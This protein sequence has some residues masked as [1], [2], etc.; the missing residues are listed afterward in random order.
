[1]A[2]VRIVS[3]LSLKVN[4]TT[5][6]KNPKLTSFSIKCIAWLA[7]VYEIIFRFFFPI[8]LYF[9]RFETNSFF[10]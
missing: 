6:T 9:A 3:L 10:C 7:L 5:A 4:K 8:S 1:M 2:Q